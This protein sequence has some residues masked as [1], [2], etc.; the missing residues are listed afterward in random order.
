M[1]NNNSKTNSTSNSNK[2]TNNT[3]NIGNNAL[4]IISGLGLQGSGFRF[5]AFVFMGTDIG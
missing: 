2:N 4:V 5:S 3:N 1:N